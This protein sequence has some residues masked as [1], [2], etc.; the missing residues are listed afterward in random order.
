MLDIWWAIPVAAR[1]VALFALAGF[2][3]GVGTAAMTRASEINQQLGFAASV[4]EFGR[5]MLIFVPMLV[6]FGGAL[7]TTGESNNFSV[8]ANTLSFTI[9]A[10][11]ASALMDGTIR[12]WTIQTW[13]LGSLA[14]I[15]VIL[16]MI[17]LN[18][19]S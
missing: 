15:C 12:D 1:T 17:N 6:V 9:A 16:F 19:Q 10:L 5:A 7:Y 2:L 4:P 11:L 3:D 8:L 14:V 18:A 13:I